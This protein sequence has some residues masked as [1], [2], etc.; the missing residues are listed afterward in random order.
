MGFKKLPL[1][2]EKFLRK[3]ICT[4]NTAQVLCNL[5]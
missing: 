5:F 2:S 3:I 1:N 4:D